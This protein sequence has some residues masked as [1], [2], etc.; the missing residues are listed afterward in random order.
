MPHVTSAPFVVPA[1]GGKLIEEFVGASTGTASHS[2]AHMVAP[3]GWD[4]PWQRPAFDETTIVVAGTMR[5][6]H[7]T[8][9]EGDASGGHTDVLPG[10][11]IL[12]RAGERIRYANASAT[13]PCLYWAVCS[14]AFSPGTV[15]REEN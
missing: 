5:V 7:D 4:E 10:E 13:E 8:E 15:H 9:G 1:P 12:C 11:T 2:V 6:F 14:P 3:P